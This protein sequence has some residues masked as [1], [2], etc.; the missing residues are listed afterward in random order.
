MYLGSSCQ[1]IKVLEMKLG[2]ARTM[3]DRELS[4]RKRAEQER[5]KFQQQM[6]ILRHI[7]MDEH[8]V[9]MSSSSYHCHGP[10]TF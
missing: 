2:Q 5:D 3:L 6:Q 10:V 4:L 9:G 7:I 8:I 1:D